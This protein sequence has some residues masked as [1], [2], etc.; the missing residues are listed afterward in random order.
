MSEN[1]LLEEDSPFINVLGSIEDK[2]FPRINE[3]WIK[4]DDIRFDEPK[5]KQ[6]SEEVPYGSMDLGV[7]PNITP[8]VKPGE[9]VVEKESN[10]N[11][12][13]KESDH[14]E[15]KKKTVLRFATPIDQK[16]EYIDPRIPAVTRKVRKL[17]IRSEEDL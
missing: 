8:K 3:G 13:E 15:P 9:S 2:S 4:K 1:E 7:D 11:L 17:K 14:F 10:K 16:P 6:T 5:P 12:P